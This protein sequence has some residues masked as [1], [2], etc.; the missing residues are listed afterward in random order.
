LSRLEVRLPGGFEV[1]RGGQSVSGFESQKVRAL[2]AYLVLHGGSH[3][4]RDRLAGLRN[5]HLHR[6][7]QHR[8]QSLASQGMES[9]W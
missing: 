5:P 7:R 8:R 6:L 9:A 4:S 1:W 3:Q 2:L